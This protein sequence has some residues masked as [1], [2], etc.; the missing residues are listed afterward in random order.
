M[1][2]LREESFSGRLPGL[3]AGPFGYTITGAQH[4]EAG[5]CR[6]YTVSKGSLVTRLAL[7]LQQGVVRFAPEL[8]LRE[9]LER[10]LSEFQAKIGSSGHASYEAR[11]ESIHDDLVVALMLA[12]HHAQSSRSYGVSRTFRI[13]GSESTDA[14]EPREPT[15]A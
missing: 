13:D 5:R 10:E 2:W 7:G 1:D 14:P 15:V 8:P 12:L 3:A 11:V 6:G 9:A 4:D